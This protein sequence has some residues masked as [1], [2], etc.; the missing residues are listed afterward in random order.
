MRAHYAAPTAARGLRPLP[1]FQENLDAVSIFQGG[2]NEAEGIRDIPGMHVLGFAEAHEGVVT[3]V[4]D[5]DAPPRR[6][7]SRDGVGGFRGRLGVGVEPDP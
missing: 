6:I 3:L 2:E 4:E 5:L 7:G 1:A